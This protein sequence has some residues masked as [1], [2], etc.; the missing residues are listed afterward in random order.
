MARLSMRTNT[1]TIS[2]L[3]RF[4]MLGESMP[5]RFWPGATLPGRHSNNR[6]T[7]MIRSKNR[8]K[9][10][11]D[12][13]YLDLATNGEGGVLLTGQWQ[14]SL[15]SMWQSSISMDPRRACP[16]TWARHGGRWA[17]PWPSSEHALQ[18][19]ISLTEI[20]TCQCKEQI[21]QS[22]PM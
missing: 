8:R 13:F 17:C 6:R 3:V 22:P 21:G 14:S 16:S 19:Y 4:P 1:H 10:L 15:V 20:S 7:M 2:R 12:S 11:D 9:K 18:M 5:D